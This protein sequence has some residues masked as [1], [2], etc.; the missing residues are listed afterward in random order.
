[1]QLSKVCK[2]VSKSDSKNKKK[3]TKWYTE[4]HV[5]FGFSFHYLFH[6]QLQLTTFE[7]NCCDMV[8]NF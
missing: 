5:I 6:H 3:M 8:A 7:I 1:M 4:N 2:V